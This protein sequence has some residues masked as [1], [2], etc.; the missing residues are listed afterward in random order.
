MLPTNRAKCDVVV[1]CGGLGTRLGPVLGDRPKPMMPVLG[2]PFLEYVIDS[3]LDYGLTRFVFC[4]GFRAESIVEHFRSYRGI[5]A[6]FSRED[7]LLGTAGALKLC[8]P[9]IRSE[10]IVVVNGDSLCRVRYDDLMAKHAES[11]VLLTM[12]LARD[13]ERGDAGFVRIGKSGM[14]SSFQEK[15][16][17]GGELYLNAGVL[18]AERSLMS[19]IPPATV[20]S[21]E[22]DIVPKLMVR[23]IRGFVADSPCHDIGTP[24]R[25]AVFEKSLRTIRCQRVTCVEPQ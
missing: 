16:R 11:R 9:N 20:C 10:R 21:F 14:I 12:V 6:C 1:L 4:V 13:D 17:L 3:L 18:V 19:V 22:R 15:E 2:R 5:E 23:G 7:V 25:L 24:D 8:E